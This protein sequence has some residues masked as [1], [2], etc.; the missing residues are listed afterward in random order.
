MCELL[1]REYGR[2]Q[3]T[4]RGRLLDELILTI[5]SQNTTAKNCS[6]AFRV[7]SERFMTWDEVRSAGIEDIADAI[8]VG[9]LANRKA[10]RIKEILEQIYRRQGN[11]DI[12]W[13]ADLPEQEAISYLLAFDGV[14]RKTAACV[15]MFGLGRPVMP[16]DTHVHRVA[17]RLGLIGGMS[18]D[19]AHD[20]LAKLVPPDAVYS[21]HVNMVTHGRRVC[22]PRNPRCPGCILKEECDY[23]AGANRA[24]G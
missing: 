2:A 13:I 24:G 1:E 14:G 17:T 19:A 16:V 8:R 10:P 5:L 7:L 11:L 20:A 22:R 6:E 21:C 3:W 23:D 9:G 4:R 15:L 12:E 18:V